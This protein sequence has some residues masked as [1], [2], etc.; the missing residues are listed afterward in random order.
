MKFNVMYNTYLVVRSARLSNRRAPKG[1]DRTIGAPG[2]RDPCLWLERGVGEKGGEGR[3]H[4]GSRKTEG[5][6]RRAAV[7]GRDRRRAIRY[8]YPGQGNRSL[9]GKTRVAVEGP[10]HFPRGCR[11]RRRRLLSGGR[12]PRERMEERG[13]R[14]N[15]PSRASEGEGS[16]SLPRA[17]WI[18]PV[19]IS[20]IDHYLSFRLRDINKK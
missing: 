4:E 17:V 3:S 6:P 9:L 19:E 20:S 10:F 12:E 7:V 16:P 2:D 5:L 13:W 18:H 11:H 14:V 8:S 1:K 15:S